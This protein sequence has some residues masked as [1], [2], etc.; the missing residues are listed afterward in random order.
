MIRNGLKINF[1]RVMV[2]LV[3][4]FCG[5]HDWTLSQKRSDWLNPKR[6]PYYHL[7]FW[8][9][10]CISV[11]EKFTHFLEIGLVIMHLKLFRFFFH[12]I[13]PWHLRFSIRSIELPWQRHGNSILRMENRR[14]HGNAVTLMLVFHTNK[15]ITMSVCHGNHANFSHLYVDHLRAQNN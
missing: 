1:D 8:N 11:T 10:T 12:L 2:M 3:K 7:N 4:Y 6:K 5:F 15:C 14:C 9:L 13:L